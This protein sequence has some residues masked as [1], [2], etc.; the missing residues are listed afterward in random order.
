MEN[1]PGDTQIK[2]T[3]FMATTLDFRDGTRQTYFIGK[4]SNPNCTMSW[5]KLGMVDTPPAMLRRWFMADGWYIDKLCRKALCPSC[6]I[7]QRNEARV[8]RTKINKHKTIVIT[9]EPEDQLR[10]DNLYDEVDAAQA[11][12]GEIERRITQT[13]Y[14]ILTERAGYGTVP[15][16]AS[17]A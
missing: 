16:E 3:C 11:L 17:K 6:T 14:T 12:I 9:L 4:C 7:R 1:I 8:V 15:D 5:Q 2:D 10:I 13:V